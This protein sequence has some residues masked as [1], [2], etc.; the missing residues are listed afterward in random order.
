MSLQFIPKVSPMEHQAKYLSLSW[1]KAVHGFFW[2]PGTGKTKPAIDTAE[3]LYTRGGED[4]R[5]DAVIVIAPPGVHLNWLTDEI[6]AHLNE[7]VLEKS[8]FYV[9]DTHKSRNVGHRPLIEKL[10]KHAGLSWLFISYAS[11]M[12]DAGKNLV[13]R[14]LQR[15]RCL[16]IADESHHIKEPGTK[17][18]KRVVASAFY[19][20]YRRLLTGSP[21]D[22][23]PMGMYTQMRFLDEKIWEKEGIGSTFAEYKV[24]FGVWKTF[25]LREGGQFE[26]LIAYRNLDQ[27]QAIM[28][29]Y[30]SRVLFDDVVDMPPARYSKRYHE[31]TPVQRRLYDQ[32]KN[33]FIADIDGGGTM[34][35]DLTIVRLMRL[36]QIVCG[37]YV[38]DDEEK[39]QRIPGPNTRLEVLEESCEA[40]G[41]MQGIIWSR[42]SA[43]IDQ[44]CDLLG[45]KAARYD[46]RIRPDECARNKLA[47]QKGDKQWF[48][49][50]QSKGAEGLTLHQ[51]KKA[52]YY[53]NS[54]KLIHRKQ[55]EARIRRKGQMTDVAVE[56]CDI[57]AQG[58]VDT[59]TTAALRAKWDIATLITGDRV[60]DWLK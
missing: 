18:T 8:Y 39:L 38:N 19:A 43:D 25:E 54:H 9:Y 23:G 24:H 60:R 36:Q 6:P 10:V 28:Q 26:K 17:R 29:K 52:F 44:I 7:A 46:G 42:F 32:L 51:G 11:M 45:T 34:T 2:D 14:M 4:G 37:Y 22:E 13:W 49:G 15:R 20:P 57:Q 56:F 47:F 5:I 27:L 53:C 48:V 40:L 30:G 12:T 1:D 41:N 16:Y 21:V 31:L 3:L 33:E 55:T 58:T 50:N 59:Q 35:A